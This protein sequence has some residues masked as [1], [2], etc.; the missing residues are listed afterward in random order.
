MNNSK[1]FCSTC[2]A[3]EPEEKLYKLFK[4]D[5]RLCQNCIN[6]FNLHREKA[7]KSILDK[8]QKDKH[9]F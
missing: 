4:H 6:E 8:M 3:W 5:K 7:E 2:S 1:Y 9:G